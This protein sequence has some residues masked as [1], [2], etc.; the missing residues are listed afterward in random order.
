[1]DKAAAL[2]NAM[3]AERAGKDMSGAVDHLSPTTPPPAT[4]SAWSAS[5][6]AAC[7]PSSSPPTGATR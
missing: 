6:W 7:S 4:A 2:M 3:P 1:M 5:A